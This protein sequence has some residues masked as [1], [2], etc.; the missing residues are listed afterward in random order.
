MAKIISLVKFF[1]EEEEKVV[2]SNE[3]FASIFHHFMKVGDALTSQEFLRIFNI[4]KHTQ[5]ILSLISKNLN[6]HRHHTNQCSVGG[7]RGGG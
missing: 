3:G 1:Q 6:C 7:G 2:Q 4:N 5:Q